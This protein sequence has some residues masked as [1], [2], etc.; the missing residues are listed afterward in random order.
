MAGCK[1]IFIEPN[2]INVLMYLFDELHKLDYIPRKS[3]TQ[4]KSE[5][6]KF[7]NGLNP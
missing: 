2:G 4:L 5:F 1:K 3:W 7:T 6:H